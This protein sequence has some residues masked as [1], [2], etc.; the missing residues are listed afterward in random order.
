MAFR[1]RWLSDGDGTLSPV[2]DAEAG[3]D[4]ARI[5]RYAH[6]ASVATSPD[7]GPSGVVHLHGFHLQL[8][9]APDTGSGHVV[10]HCGRAVGRLTPMP[11]TSHARNGGLNP[12][13]RLHRT[14]TA[15]GPQIPLGCHGVRSLSAHL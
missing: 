3:A 9:P 2:C 15:L 10:L 4:S 11:V 1:S 6:H 14:G 5:K 8:L 12:E 7:G 13:I